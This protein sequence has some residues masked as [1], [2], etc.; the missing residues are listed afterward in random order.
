MPNLEELRLIFTELAGLKYSDDYSLRVIASYAERGLKALE[1]PIRLREFLRTIIF[2]IRKILTVYTSDP[3]M[4]RIEQVL[5]EWWLNLRAGPRRF[6]SNATINPI[7][8]PGDD[9][10]PGSLIYHFAVQHKYSREFADEMIAWLI[11]KNYQAK[12]PEDVHLYLMH[13]VSGVKQAGVVF[14][15]TQQSIQPVRKLFQQSEIAYDKYPMHFGYMIWV[16]QEQR[17][18]AKSL[19]NQ[20]GF[21]TR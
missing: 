11:D 18:E 4:N 8:L 10:V 21:E 5:Q 9:E 16:P 1:D 3:D 15:G 7:Y 12:R 13:A 17:L 6:E 20:A 19:I 2:E 14:Q